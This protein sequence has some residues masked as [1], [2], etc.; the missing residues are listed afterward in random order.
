MERSILLPRKIVCCGTPSAATAVP[1]R[2]GRRRWAPGISSSGRGGSSYVTADLAR[3]ARLPWCPY[4]KRIYV[5]QDE[6]WSVHSKDCDL[7]RDNVE[8]RIILDS[9]ARAAA[10]RP[11]RFARRFDVANSTQNTPLNRIHT[12]R[13]VPAWRAAAVTGRGRRLPGTLASG[14]WRRAGRGRAAAELPMHQRGSPPR[15]GR[16]GRRGTVTTVH[17]QPATR[18]A[19]RAHR[20]DRHRHAAG[21]GW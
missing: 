9:H 19:N 14:P 17:A 13:S 7:F 5:H 3:S 21:G 20:G 2:S 16:E 1:R 4:R 10:D 15:A 18:G 11:L 12:Q 6:R 8:K